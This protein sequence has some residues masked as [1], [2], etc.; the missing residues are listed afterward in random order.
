MLNPMAFGVC[1]ASQ[2]L[3]EWKGQCQDDESVMQFE[4]MKILF[5]DVVMLQVDVFVFC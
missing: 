3:N 5:V 4:G 1:S 2:V